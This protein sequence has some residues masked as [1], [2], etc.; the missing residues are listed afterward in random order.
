MTGVSVET[1][2]VSSASRVHGKYGA[3][4]EFVW[5]KVEP[6][7]TRYLAGSSAAAASL[8]RLRRAVGS[9]PGADPLVWEETLEGFPRSL[10]GSDTKPSLEERAA[11]AAIALYAVH[12]QSKSNQRMHKRGVNI[13]RAAA[14][15]G[16]AIHGD[17]AVLRRFHALG[18]ASSLD[19]AVNHARGLISQFRSESIALDYGR[20]AADL[21]RIQ[22]PRYSDAV[23]LNWGRHYYFKPIDPAAK[24]QTDGGTTTVT[25]NGENK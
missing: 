9:E 21:A 7:Q 16:I 14:L 18:T 5:L 15:L 25:P 22:D 20:F 23:R 8:A 2:A 1:E 3:L 24:T 10:W 19:E 12:Q 6:L 11:H 4:E 13:G 17:D